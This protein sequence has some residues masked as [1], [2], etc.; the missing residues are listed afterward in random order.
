MRNFRPG[1]KPPSNA[2]FVKS[3]SDLSLIIDSKK[4]SEV[5]LFRAGL[6][7]KSSLLNKGVK[8]LNI[9][10]TR[11]PD[12]GGI[13]TISRALRDRQYYQEA[14]LHIV[15]SRIDEG[16]VIKTLQYKLEPSSCYCSNEMVAYQAGLTLL[17]GY[18]SNC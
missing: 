5:I 3:N 16:E 14:T 6:I 15:T 11:L 8:I 9:H 4:P 1:N 12:Y 18:L 17:N 10:C 13:G 7:I 2:P